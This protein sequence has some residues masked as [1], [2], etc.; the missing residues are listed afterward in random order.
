M[1]SKQLGQLGELRAQYDFIKAGW[2]VSVPLGDYCSYDFVAI[3][4]SKTLKIQVKTTKMIHH[5]DGVM[6]FSVN[7]ANYYVDKVY[8][9]TDCDYFYLYCLENEMGYLYPVSN[10][11]KSDVFLRL[12][13]PKNN[14]TKGVNFA[15][16]FEFN[17]I[18]KEIEA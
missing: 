16:D 11:R 14:Q 15:K 5:Q 1:N 17:K 7:S 8:T 18:V 12:N 3:K 6:K 10:G 13:I 9:E 2:E 4:A